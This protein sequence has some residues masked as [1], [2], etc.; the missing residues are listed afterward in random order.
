MARPIKKSIYERIES[1]KDEILNKE[2]ELN[3]LNKEL[4]DLFS[5][6][7]REEMERLL[8]QV[9]ANGLDIELALQKLSGQKEPDNMED[10]TQEEIK[11]RR[12]RTN[13]SEENEQ[14]SLGTVDTIE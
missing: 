12:K 7:D 2:K 3:E 5:E 11:P 10:N 6:R 9:R 8:A 14:I 4:Q 13:K 1:K